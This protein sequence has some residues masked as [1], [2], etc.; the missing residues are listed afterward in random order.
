[1]ISIVANKTMLTA[2]KRVKGR[3]EI[4]DPKGQI[5]GVYFPIILGHARNHAGM[6][7]LIDSSEI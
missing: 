4:R 2:L 7:T 6:I 5:I 3:T 1:M